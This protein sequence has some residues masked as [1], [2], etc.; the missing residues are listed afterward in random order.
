MNRY[1]ACLLPVLLILFSE[2]AALNCCRAQV[3]RPATRPSRTPV[4]PAAGIKSARGFRVAL[5][6][7]VPRATQGS[8][9][10]MTVDPKGR[11]IVSDQFGSLYRVTLPAQGESLTDRQVKRID[12]PLGEAHGLL[13]AFDSLYVVVNRGRHYASGLYRVRD[14]N[15]D[16]QLDSVELLRR[17]TEAESMARTAWSW[18][19]TA[20]RSTSWPATPREFPLSPARW[21]RASGARTI[22]S[23]GCMTP[24]S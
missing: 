7:T 13:W 1:R 15:G 6:Y 16:D 11:L 22:F 17:L 10:N 3:P 23:R 2:I 19:P 9:V 8:W 12:V 20:A 5:L 14:T 21:F 18:P 4:I 24:R